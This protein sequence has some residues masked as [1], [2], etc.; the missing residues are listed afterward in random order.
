[1][2]RSNVKKALE[3][4][5]KISQK[6][7]FNQS[8]DVIV[9]LKDLN[10][11]KAEDNVEIF[12]TLPHKSDKKLKIC[13]LVSKDSI[14]KAKIFNKAISELEF[15]KY[16]DK[17]QINRL[18]KDYDIFVASPS[19]MGK[20]ATTFG[21]I[22]GP[23]GKMPNPKA[24]QILVPTINF[25]GLK[26]KL[27]RTVK[28]KTKKEPILKCSIGKENLTDDNLSENFM[29]IYNALVHS[30]PK[31]EN[32]IKNIFIKTTMSKPIIVK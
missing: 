21:K 11:K 30:L 1:M 13:A 28:L 12:V 24:F 8:I 10:I 4:L 26:D 17:K 2:D 29:T 23:K 25:E 7:K 9:N 14:E 3:E 18:A 19:I 22:L 16:K 20:V 31:E 27:E 32:N 15:T 5:R 6:R